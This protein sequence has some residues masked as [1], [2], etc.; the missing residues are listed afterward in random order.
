MYELPIDGFRTWVRIPPPPPIN[1]PAEYDTL[2]FE[3][4]GNIINVILADKCQVN[5]PQN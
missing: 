4:T 2:I 3:L 1:K 5:F